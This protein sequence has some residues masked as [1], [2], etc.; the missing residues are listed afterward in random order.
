MSIVP[1]WPWMSGSVL[2][3][4]G[5]QIRPR[6]RLISTRAVAV[7]VVAAPDSADLSDWYEDGWMDCLFGVLSHTASTSLK[8]ARPTGQDFSLFFFYFYFFSFVILHHTGPLSLLK[9]WIQTVSERRYH[10]YERVTAECS[11]TDRIWEYWLLLA[12]CF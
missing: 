4:V 1:W 2:W 8:A 6:P 5:A 11:C 9:R 10:R 7:D 12:V 3:G